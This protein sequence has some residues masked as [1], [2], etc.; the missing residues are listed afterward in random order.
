MITL[1]ENDLKENGR[2]SSKGNQ[3]KWQSG[4]FWYKADYLG[5][6][7]LSEY[8]CS[9]M[10]RF[11]DLSETEYTSYETEEIL[12]KNNVFKGCRSK[13][14]L[15]EGWQ[16]VT[17]ERLFKTRYGRSL[18]ADLYGIHNPG[19]RLNYLV[20]EVERATGIKDF[21]I[22]VNRL[23]TIDALFLNEDR[24]T[25]NIA[26][27]L[28]PNENFHCCPVFDLGASLL[29]DTTLDYPMGADLY[30]LID[31]V[32]GKTICD[33]LYEAL[34]VSEELYGENIHFTFSYREIRDALDREP[35]YPADYKKRVLAVLLEQRRKYPY[36][37]K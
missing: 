6:E 15:S 2:M 5:Y 22:Y 27:L 35:Y 8:L 36:L 3:L 32:K 16:A 9:E 28:D 34:T 14:F 23:L 11:S 29:S 19:D 21:G 31:T 30:T 37:F 26:V 24:H 13:N 33:S 1:F 25:H 4:D 7:G 10:L 12:Y 17:L 18:G 20:E